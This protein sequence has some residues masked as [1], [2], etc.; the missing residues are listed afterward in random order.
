ML[1]CD[2]LKRR[3]QKNAHQK[4]SASSINTI[5]WH[6]LC[7]TSDK[8]HF[9][10]EGFTFLESEGIIMK[11]LFSLTIFTLV[12]MAS[13]NT[14]AEGFQA[15]HLLNRCKGAQIS[16]DKKSVV[17]NLAENETTI[18]TRVK[19]KKA[20]KA[21]EFDSLPAELQNRIP[22]VNPNDLFECADVG[23]DE[24]VGQIMNAAGHVIGYAFRQD[25]KCSDMNLIRSSVISFYNTKG[26]MVSASMADTSTV[27][28]NYGYID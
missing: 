28:P 5:N 24:K 1:D 12:S 14:W 3:C 22:A 11:N 25:N 17:C 26:D 13:L 18:N 23:L 8:R 7:K 2:K 20:I 19:V 21:I 27:I 6:G 9:Q 15:K 4:V 16:K 10:I